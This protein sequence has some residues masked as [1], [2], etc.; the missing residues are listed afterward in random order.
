MKNQGFTLI[1][2]LVVIG[3]ITILATIVLVAVNPA[4]QFAISRDTARRND[5]YQILNA[6]HQYSIDNN[7]RFPTQVQTNNWIDIGTGGLNLN[8]IL[9]PT[10]IPAIPE[11]P[12]NGTA[13]LTR[14]VLAVDTNSRLTASA[15]SAEVE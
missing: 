13:G 8:A 12:Q 7:G 10:Y 9:V 1:E 5:L 15:S 6:V 2:L 14:Y 4:R 3:I 11:D